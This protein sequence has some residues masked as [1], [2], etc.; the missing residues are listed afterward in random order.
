MCTRRVLRLGVCVC[1]DRNAGCARTQWQGDMDIRLSTVVC[2][3]EVAEK[4]VAYLAG[5]VLV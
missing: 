5:Y 3:T 4:C 2:A 1:V